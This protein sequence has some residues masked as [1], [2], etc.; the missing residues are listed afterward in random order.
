MSW[1][2][3]LFGQTSSP[4]NSVIIP[5]PLAARLKADGHDLQI[6]AVGVIQNHFEAIDN[7]KLTAEEGMPFWLQRES[8]NSEI[9]DELRERVTQRHISEE[10]K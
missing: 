8:A 2:G 1:L 4:A 3:R 5:E 7:P 10:Q 9:E 6:E